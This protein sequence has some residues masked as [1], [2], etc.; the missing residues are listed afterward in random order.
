MSQRVQRYRK[1][2]KKYKIATGGTVEEAFSQP[3]IY[4]P[5]TSWCYSPSIDWAGKVIERITGQTL[6]EYMMT[7]IWRPLGIKDITFWPEQHPDMKNRITSM[8][9]R[10]EESGKVIPDHGSAKMPRGIDCFGGHGAFAS[11]PDYF[12]ILHS[13]LLDDETLL[14]RSTT[15]Q[16][17]QPQLTKESQEAQKSLMA[18]PADLTLFVGAFPKNIPLDWG[19]GGILTRQADEAWRGKHTL[20]WSGMPNLFWACV[21][22]S[23]PSSPTALDKRKS[24]TTN[25]TTVHRPLDRSLRR[26]RR[27]S[28]TA[29]RR[30]GWKDDYAV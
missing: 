20:I 10:D 19:I 8:T 9:I 5:G 11:M 12:K 21:F 3:L 16:M 17:F 26:I 24:P 27:P 29:R 28:I 15:A 6:E 13:L 2:T 23:I 4:E 22:F 7:H 1:H 25:T 14:K 30:Q 18:N